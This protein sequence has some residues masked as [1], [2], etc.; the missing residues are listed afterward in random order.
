MSHAGD[1]AS[2]SP[3]ADKK[4][5]EFFQVSQRLED[6]KL[7]QA[8]ANGPLDLLT[9]KRLMAAVNGDLQTAF[10]TA[11]KLLGDKNILERRHAN[12]CT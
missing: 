4:R 6:A 8:F 12:A 5:M 1:A 10:A 9:A 3:T 7:M 11:T 2:N